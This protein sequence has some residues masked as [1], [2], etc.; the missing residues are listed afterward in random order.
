MLFALSVLLFSCGCGDLNTIYG[1]LERDDDSVNGLVI[2]H[3][4]LEQKARVRRSWLLNKR[5][6]NDDIDL[7]VHV[8]RRGDT[9]SDEV[10]Q[11]LTDWLNARAE[12]QVLLVLRDGAMGADLCE[13][14]ASQAR[15][16][17]AKLDHRWS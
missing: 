17:A 4:A 13:L 10:M 11:W 8:D 5:L 6:M 1:T 7:L 12:R 3:Q 2:F 14:W 9:P 15:S 16:E